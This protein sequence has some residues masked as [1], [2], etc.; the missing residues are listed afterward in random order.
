MGSNY[1]LDVNKLD[2]S[3]EYLHRLCS[4]EQLN[5]ND[6]FWNQLLSFKNTLQFTKEASEQ[7]KHKKDLLCSNW[8]K[9]NL[10]TRN[11]N[12]LIRVY[13]KLFDQLKEMPDK[14]VFQFVLLVFNF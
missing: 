7:F 10:Q 3:N 4:D 11:L 6:P 2:D 5:E 9:N 12:T 14:L 13:F 1:S 8:T